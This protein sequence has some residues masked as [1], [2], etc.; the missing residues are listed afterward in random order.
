MFQIVDILFIL[1]TF[2]SNFILFKNIFYYYGS[3]CNELF[4]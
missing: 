4:F 3:K 2:I 1:N